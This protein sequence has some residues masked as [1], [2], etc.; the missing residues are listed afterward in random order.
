MK[1]IVEVTARKKS[2][3]TASPKQDGP[4]QLYRKAIQASAIFVANG[5]V[6]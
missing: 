5:S 3:A 4:Q 2:R 6:D 1:P